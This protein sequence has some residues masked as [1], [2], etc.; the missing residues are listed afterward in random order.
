MS[1]RSGE[2]VTLRA[3]RQEVGNDAARFFYVL[4]KSDQHLD[5]DLDLAKS[6][7]TDNQ[8]YYV[9][10]AHARI[11]SVLEEWGGHAPELSE[12]DLA[13]LT[14]PQE[15]ALMRELMEF[16]QAI[17][18][19][20][21]DHAPHVIAFYLKD[22]AAGLHSYYN[23]VRFLV[24]DEQVRLGRLALVAAV[25]QVLSTGLQMLGVSAPRKM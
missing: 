14:M 7:T 16:P 12:A 15:L 17:E 25:G 4:R 18:D 23:S 11:C 3:L 10:Y 22:L 13:A 24:D 19:A 8:V 6:Q 20:A 2:F 9:Q 1:T 5:F 21:R